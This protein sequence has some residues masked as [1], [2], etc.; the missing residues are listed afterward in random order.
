MSD[1]LYTPYSEELKLIGDKWQ[2]PDQY[3]HFTEHL[4]AVYEG[5]GDGQT[6]E[7]YGSA[8]PARFYKLKVRKGHDSMGELQPGYEVNTGSGRAVLELAVKLA[9]EISGGMIGFKVDNRS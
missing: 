7:L 9:E 4:L 3:G 1:Y 2:G 5:E 8:A 6:V